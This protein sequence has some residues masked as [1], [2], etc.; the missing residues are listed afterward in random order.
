MHT[1]NYRVIKQIIKQQ[2]PEEHRCTF[3]YTTII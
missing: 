3:L 2:Q 1:S